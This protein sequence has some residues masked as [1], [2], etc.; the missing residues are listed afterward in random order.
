MDV[1]FD[2]NRSRTSDIVSHLLACDEKFV[3][4][5]NESVSIPSYSKKLVSY[6]VRFEAWSNKTLIGLVAGYMNDFKSLNSF[7]TNVSVLPNWYGMGIAENLLRNYLYFVADSGFVCVMLNVDS[8]NK[9]ALSLYKK[10]GF[11][12]HEDKKEKI[13]KMTFNLRKLK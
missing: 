6:A 11:L 5:L 2:T 7:I 8:R 4:K 10:F 1:I 13:V 12:V 9:R 3:L